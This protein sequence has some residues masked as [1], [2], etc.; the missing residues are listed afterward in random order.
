MYCFVQRLTACLLQDASEVVAADQLTDSCRVQISP[1]APL[2]G[3]W[4]P[5]QC[6]SFHLRFQVPWTLV[7]TA[8]KP[9]PGRAWQDTSIFQELVFALASAA[10]GHWRRFP[11]VRLHRGVRS[12][13]WFPG[14]SSA[15]SATRRSLAT[16]C[17]STTWK[18]PS[19][20]RKRPLG[21]KSSSFWTY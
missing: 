20:G 18:A 17:T 1:T 6:A 14:A 11:T 16:P 7:G 3:K 19:T 13:R 8:E 5:R 4:C 2:Y 21:K 9:A 15:R 12:D 10:L